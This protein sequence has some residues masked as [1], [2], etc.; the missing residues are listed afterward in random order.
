MLDRV[1][2]RA[3][4]FDILH[5]HIDQ[6]HF[7]LFRPMADRTVTTLHG[8]QDLPDL[9]PLYLGFAECRWCR[10]PTRSASRCRMP[11]SW[12][13]STTAFPPT[14]IARLRSPRRL[15]RFPRAHFAGKAAGPRHPDRAGA[16]HSAQDRRQ[17]RQGRRSLFPR[18]DRAAAERPGRRIHRRDQRAQKKQIS[19]RGARAA[20]SDRLAGAV[21]PRR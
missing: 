1:A 13:P 12:R 10:S 17:G 16:R 18:T 6:F 4:E 15:R 5:F 9:K 7:P 2:T 11:T 14:C 20:V 3:D 8:R 21:R 19:R